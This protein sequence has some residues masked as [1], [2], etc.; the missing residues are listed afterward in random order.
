MDSYESLVQQLEEA[1]QELQDATA[2]HDMVNQMN[3]LRSGALS[4]QQPGLVDVRH[5][6]EWVQAAKQRT[7]DL[8]RQV[9][10]HLPPG[11]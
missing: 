6:W 7:D 10:E 4:Y 5:A 3:S 9:R 2:H 8:R 1:E 11:P